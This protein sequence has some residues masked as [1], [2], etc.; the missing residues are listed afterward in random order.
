MT[1]DATGGQRVTLQDMQV[2]G[3]RRTFTHA[4]RSD[5]PK[6]WG[7]V[8]PELFALTNNEPCETFGICVESHNE[9]AFDYLVCIPASRVDASRSHTLELLD[10]PSAT[11]ARFTHSG[12]VSELPPFI[13][14]AWSAGV[15]DLGW[16]IRHS[17][18]GIEHYPADWSPEHGP[19]YILIPLM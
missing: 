4:T 13:Q 15:A 9:G 6:M 18:L 1:T 7:E 11:Y 5:I 3:V 16:E 14:W 19:T 8:L 2:V 12:R 17:G 10:M